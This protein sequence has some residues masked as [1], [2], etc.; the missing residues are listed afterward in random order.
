MEMCAL[1]DMHIIQC[2]YSPAVN[3]NLMMLEKIEEL[4]SEIQVSREKSR[5]SVS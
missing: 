2:D 3:N 5:D 1:E 4:I